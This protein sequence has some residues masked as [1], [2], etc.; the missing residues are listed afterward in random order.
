MKIT[1]IILVGGIYDKNL[2]TKCLN[3]VSW[4]DEIVKVETDGLKG[5]FADWRNEG[6]RKSNGDWLLYV[7]TDEEITDNLQKEIEFT[8]NNL[9][10]TNSAYAIPR[11]NFIFGKEMKHCGLWP[12]FV[13]RLIKKDKLKG[14]TGDLHEQPKVDGKTCHLKESLIH[15][16]HKT[17][18][19]MVEK[20][21]DWSEIEARLMFDAKHPPMNIFRFFSAGLREFWRRMVIQIAF[22]DGSDGIIYALY[23]VFSRLI[24]YSKL[25][26]LQM[27]SNTSNKGITGN[28]G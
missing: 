26:E 22:L 12:D 19:E 9:Q 2:L 23:Q 8:I 13:L 11:R 21:N 7:D 16:K 4:C 5:S 15:N 10:F 25:W 28:R 3:S 24:S 14:W 20:T 1:A 6:A 18:A 17:L 27:K